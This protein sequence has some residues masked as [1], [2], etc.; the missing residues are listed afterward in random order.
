MLA[1]A[2][3]LVTSLCYGVSNYV[4]P[5]LSRDLPTY[6]VLIAGQVVAFAASAS[7]LVATAAALPGGDRA[8]RRGGRGRR[9]RVGADLVLP[10]RVAGAAEHRHAGRLAGGGRAGDGGRRVG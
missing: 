2:L 6:P 3:A 4:G 5:A 9:Q 8:G 10:G 1:A 7:V